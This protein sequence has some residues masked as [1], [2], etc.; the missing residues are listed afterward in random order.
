VR[1]HFLGAPLPNGFPGAQPVKPELPITPQARA[2]AAEPC[3][4]CHR[5][6]FPIGYALENFDPLGRWRTHDQL[7]PVDTSGT[8]VDGTPTNSVV[9][10]RQA[11]LQRPDAFRTTMVESLVA[12]STT[13]TV[14]VAASSNQTPRNLTATTLVR[15]RRILRQLP[16][17][18]W[19]A[20]IAAV[21]RE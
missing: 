12:Y 6:F 17:P 11:L 4:N 13:G 9:E 16:E 18:R 21:V 8:F 15:A 1:Q 3:G 14:P 19:S 20:V 5:N 10:L 2:L 7:G